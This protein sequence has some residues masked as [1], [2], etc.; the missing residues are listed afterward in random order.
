[1]TE[2]RVSVIIPTLDEADNL[3]KLLPALERQETDFEVEIIVIDSG[4]KDATLDVCREF[5][6]RTK[7]IPPGTFDH[8][9]TRQEAAGLASGEILVFT[10]GDAL[11]SD[12]RWLAN[13]VGPAL[14][15]ENV[16]GCYGMQVGPDAPEINPLEQGISLEHEIALDV[17]SGPHAREDPGTGRIFKKVADGFRFDELPPREQRRLASFD[18][19]TSCARRRILIEEVPFESA[20]FGE[21]FQWA[22]KVLERGYTVVFEP[23]AKVFH[24]HEQNFRYFFRRMW[25]DQKII[26]EVFGLLGHRSV[27]DCAGS[28]WRE[29]GA[30]WSSLRARGLG[31]AAQLKWFAYNLKLITANRLARYL[32]EA[33]G[34]PHPL[35]WIADR[36]QKKLGTLVTIRRPV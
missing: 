17:A 15:D 30:A 22:A 11:P 14:E 16:A 10:V 26:R 21:D 18:N 6:V 7:E 1:M 19:C 23:R 25:L 34:R 27:V 28:W 35:G 36:V 24:Y 29:T 12:D 13:L 9:R 3:R 4:S 8:G 32:T 20:R 5:G 2:P 33:E 31:R